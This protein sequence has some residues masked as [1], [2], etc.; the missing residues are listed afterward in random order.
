MMGHLAEPQRLFR[1]MEQ[2]GVHL[3]TSIR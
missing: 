3:E 2:M 1:D